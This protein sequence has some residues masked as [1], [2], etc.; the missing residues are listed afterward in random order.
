V[1]TR[2]NVRCEAARDAALGL[3]L[4]IA[5]L[6]RHPD[7]A[8]LC[9]TAE[10]R[11]VEALLAATRDAPLALTFADGVLHA[12]G[13]PVLRF[14]PTDVPFG[15]LCAAGIGGLTIDEDLRAPDALRLL[16]VLAAATTDSDPDHDI[17]ALLRTANL[18]HVHPRAAT[19]TQLAMPARADWWM[20]PPPG[21]SAPA[22]RPLVERDLGANLAARCATK[23]LD[24]LDQGAAVPAET[25]EALFGAVLA[26]D[27]F[28][29][30]A[31][32]LEQARCRPG[33]PAGVASTMLHAAEGTCEA[34]RLDPFLR[35]ASHQQALD[36][37][38]FGM[39]LGDTAANRLRDC[40]CE[41]GHPLASS[42]SDLLGP[43][44]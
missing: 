23:L 6:R 5:T 22:L 43:R 40:V 41:S 27:D 33:V 9:R 17:A 31:W 7:H 14:A 8:E 4:A 12:A 28:A 11:A 35:R 34:A 25:L 15:A 18:Q 38:A 13:E 1:A 37:L 21:A 39:Q 10:R 2:A 44:D 30:A 36:L 42:F 19:S 16:R 32:L 29:T 20:L 3:H 26:R 24:E